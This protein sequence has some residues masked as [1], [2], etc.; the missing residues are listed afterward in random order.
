[1]ARLTSRRW[2]AASAAR[3]RA[4]AARQAAGGQALPGRAAELDPG[5]AQEPDVQ[6]G[7]GEG[8]RDGGGGV[9]EE[10]EDADD[11]GGVDGAAGR[12][13]VEADVAAGDGQAEGLAGGGHAV[14]G[15][16]ERAH[17]LGPFGA[18]EVEAVGDR[19]RLGAGAG[20]VAGGLGD[21]QGGPGG[22]V[23]GGVA[24][25]AVGGQR[26]RPAASR[27]PGGRPR[28]TRGRRPCRGRRSGRTA[29]TPSA[30]RRRS[31]R[32]PGRARPRPGPRPAGPRPRLRSAG[33][34]GG[35]SGRE[36]TGP[37]SARLAAGTS[38]TTPPR[39]RDPQHPPVAGRSSPRGRWPGRPS[40]GRPRARRRAGPGRPG[41]AC[42]P[43][44]PRRAPPRPP[45]TAR[46]GAPRPGR[47][48]C[49]SRPWP[50]PRRRRS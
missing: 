32:R 45:S 17:H 30:W 27:G 22:R 25:V 42:A 7:P 35:T 44:T 6:A 1:M 39:N 21:G 10:A 34:S 41:P 16:R 2:R 19:D 29:P 50:R 12:L 5:L 13:V 40:G 4:G 46:A 8:G 9:L 24:A 38:A 49:P 18:G 47:P 33:G 31:G 23:E 43:G 28:R 15:G 3:S 37:S 14:D 36:Y 26:H 20:D 48:P 11:R